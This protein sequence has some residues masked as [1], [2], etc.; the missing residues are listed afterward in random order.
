M[1]LSNWCI[2]QVNRNAFRPHPEVL[3]LLHH[4]PSAV[5]TGY[6][7]PDH[8]LLFLGTCARR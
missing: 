4:A 8:S 6:A 2:A 5:N 7:L 1:K 3:R